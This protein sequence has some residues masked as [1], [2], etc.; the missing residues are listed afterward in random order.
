MHNLRCTFRHIREEDIVRRLQFIADQ[1]HITIDREALRTIAHVS[2]GG[3]RDAIS[4]MDQMRALESI[5]LKDVKLRIGATGQEYVE[6]VLTALH[7]KDRSAVLESIAKIEDAGVP[8]D[9]FTRQVLKHVR[10]AL[11]LA[12]AQK[13]STDHLLHIM[14]MLL[15]AIAAMRTSPV[16]GLALESALLNLC[17]ESGTDRAVIVPSQEQEEE[18]QKEE[19]KE[20]DQ[21]ERA[22]VPTAS[23]D[24][25]IEAPDLSVESLQKTWP[26]ILKETTP[27]SVKMSLKNGRVSA[28]EDN[29][30]TVSF[31]S[32]FHRDNVSDT[33]A[34]RAIEIVLEKIFKKQLRIHCTLENEQSAQKTDVVSSD[35]V[36]NLADAA[37]EIF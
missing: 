18:P 34:S 3:M 11:H 28:V 14:H 35:D 12:I 27:A 15:D 19:E 6:D 23:K 36:V 21:E 1:E 22:H 16:P 9:V 32:A 7:Q 31:A 10:E 17:D 26:T 33:E 30:V 24:A 4:L 29:V 25:T 20:E 13:Q 5:T 8:L 2:D 37:A